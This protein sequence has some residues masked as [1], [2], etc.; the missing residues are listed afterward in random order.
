[1]SLSRCVSALRNA[2]LLFVDTRDDTID[3]FIVLRSPFLQNANTPLLSDGVPV[4]HVNTDDRQ[5]FSLIRHGYL[6]SWPIARAWGGAFTQ[7]Q[8]WSAW[9]WRVD[10]GAHV[11]G[12][13]YETLPL[14]STDFQIQK[15]PYW[16]W[17]IAFK[18]KV[19]KWIV[20]VT[21]EISFH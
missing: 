7:K 15:L 5:L 6:S 9:R 8:W 14:I 20:H 11:H 4:L 19:D 10:S 3:S 21:N 13:P 16:Y 18:I 1:M 17:N 12:T 2:W